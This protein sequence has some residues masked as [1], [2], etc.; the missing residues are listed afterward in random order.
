MNK[1]LLLVTL[2]PLLLASQTDLEKRVLSL[3]KE[4]ISIKKN[5]NDNR[6]EIL[7]LIPI[8]EDVEKKSILDKINLSPE[9]EIRLDKFDYKLGNIDDVSSI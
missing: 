7:E 1:L 9:L 8:V 6:N 3:E 2:T 4:L 5:D